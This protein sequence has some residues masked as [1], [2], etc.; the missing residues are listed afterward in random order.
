PAFWSECGYTTGLVIDKAV[1]SLHGDV[2]DKE[3]FLDALKKVSLK[4]APRGP[5]KLDNLG[6]P[7]E[8]LYVYKVQKGKSGLENV[9]VDTFPNVSQFW[10]YDPEKFMESPE[11]SRSIPI[12]KFCSDK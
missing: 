2:S 7:I 4:D 1:E 6:N 5:M 10:H 9:V 11:Y 3:K 12:C 8:N